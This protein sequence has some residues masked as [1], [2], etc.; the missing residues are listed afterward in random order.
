VPV[1]NGDLI[2]LDFETTGLSPLQGDR[3]T[4][5]A[6]IRV[7]QDRIVDQ[8]Q[9]LANCGVRVSAF[10]TAYTGITQRMVDA[11]PPVRKVVRELLSFMGDT[12]VAAHNASFDQRFLDSECGHAGMTGQYQP[13]I[14]SMRVSRRVYPEL[15]SYRLES[16]ARQL[17]VSYSSAAHRAGADA[18]VTAKIMI[19]LGRDL[20]DRHSNL[21]VDSQ[22]LR[23]IMKMPVAGAGER[24]ARL[25]DA[26]PRG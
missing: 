21:T 3:I 13:F 22:L 16:L 20:L 10:I 5:V 24:L 23:R 14:C 9:S 7:S 25:A 8:Y 26:A 2:V 1:L 17:R 12:P 4:E 15:P 18:E 19:R 11:A 6:A